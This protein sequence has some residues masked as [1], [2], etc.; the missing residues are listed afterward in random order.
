M[1]QVDF[2]KLWQNFVDTVTNHYMDFNGRVGRAQFWWY[3]LVGFVLGIGV[4][5]VAAITTHLLSTLF[6]LALLLPNLGMTVRRLH[7]TGRPGIWALLLLV[8]VAVQ[9]LFGLMVLSVGVWAIFGLFYALYNLI[10]LASLV[11][12]L[13]VIYFCAQP[14]TAGDNAYGAPPAPWAPGGAATPTAPPST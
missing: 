13:I 8:P 4:S 3:V 11:A 6:V 2:N 5:I 1:D 7:D 14:G 10:A 9:I 12:L